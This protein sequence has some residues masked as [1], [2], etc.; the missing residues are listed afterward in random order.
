MKSAVAKSWTQHVLPWLGVAALGAVVVQSWRTARLEQEARLAEQARDQQVAEKILRQAPSCW[1]A[2]VE[3]SRGEFATVRDGRI[4]VPAAVGWIEPE[5]S[6]L[7]DDPVVAD[8][9]ARAAAAEFA[10]GDQA[11][12]ARA[13]D[14]L[15]AGPL[16]P[17]QRLVV[18][19]A[20]A[21]HGE[22]S[23]AVEHTAALRER[24]DAEVAV[25][26]P[27][28]LARPALARAVA[29]ALRLPRP[30]APAWAAALAPFLPADVAVG[31]AGPW[32][33]AHQQ[34]CARRAS[35]VRLQQALAAAP[36]LAAAT[37]LVATTAGLLWRL[38]DAAEDA[39]VAEAA[40]AP[41]AADAAK[42]DDAVG[43]ADAQLACLVPL[44]RFH[45]GVVHAGELGALPRWPWSV[46]VELA[47]DPAAAEAPAFAGVP[48][49]RGLR[50]AGG[51]QPAGPAWLWPLATVAL[52]LA[53]A[54][55]FRTQRRA[56]AAEAA[57]VAAQSEFLT[58]VTHELK[59]P[60]A[61]IRLLSEMLQQGR[62]VGREAEYHAMLGAEAARLSTLLENVLDLGRTERGERAFD[63]RDLDLAVVAGDAVELL[64]P[65]LARAG[66]EVAL[67]AEAP[68][69]AR[70]DRGAVTQ[71]LVAL[72]DNA[73]KYGAGTIEVAARVGDGV[74]RVE[75]R[76]HGDGVPAAERERIFERFVRGARHRN[77]ATPGAGIG[78][79]VARAAMRRFGGDLVCAEPA[80]GV[81]ARFV[82]TLPGG[83]SA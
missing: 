78:L 77:G 73:R 6:P 11:A 45:W 17:C 67:V 28:D 15:L 41:D 44:S 48:G 13:F 46:E 60:L 18:L 61:S 66:R 80:G 39:D 20:A 51:V 2:F 14:D 52:A 37:A 8:R 59:T 63:V 82:L 62:A 34:A 81:G 64:R 16:L 30:R 31:L 40:K 76:D 65:L 4:V 21:W 36:P 56:A 29:A 12:A 70:G 54:V 58:N 22:R 55:A 43:A 27:G 47:A 7:D 19:A 38:V 68:A 53:F 26:S 49:L 3:A 57:A 10:A 50:A 71:A 72:L 79:Y 75:V 74:A 25:L 32:L 35:L 1:K 83:G 69:P 9:L 23:G 24:L 42:A 5:A 33:A